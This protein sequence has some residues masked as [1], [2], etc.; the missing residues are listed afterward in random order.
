MQRADLLKGVNFKVDSTPAIALIKGKRVEVPDRFVT[1]R[2]DNGQ[3]LEVLGSRYKVIQ[4]TDA[5]LEIDKVVSKVSKR[6]TVNH[7]I[8]GSRIYSIFDLLDCEV[9]PDSK[10][11]GRLRLN[12]LFSYDGQRSHQGT[13]SVYRKIC[14]NGM[15]GFA[16][17]YV[18]KKSHCKTL[19][20]LET[21]HKVLGNMLKV[22]RESYTKLYKVLKDSPVIKA[23][24][25]EKHLA[26][27]IVKES[28]EQY[29]IERKL[30]GKDSAW[31][32]Y[33]SLTRVISHGKMQ[34]NY[35][36]LLSRT[37]SN[38]FMNQYHIT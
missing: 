28:R 22:H 25:L 4:H 26:K 33:Q 29:P 1:Y 16:S 37:V 7:K 32:Q 31:T 21:V 8:E 20:D 12:C 34:E 3:P 15:Y 11:V 19:L 36:L 18:L 14:S 6:Y 13:I 27:K 5:L 10:E 23:N 30:I 38:L 9:L 35:R 17:E 24:K 2:T